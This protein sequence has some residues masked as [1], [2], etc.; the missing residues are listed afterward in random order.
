MAHLA[1]PFTFNYS[2]LLRFSRH[3]ITYVAHLAPGTRMALGERKVFVQKNDFMSG[4]RAER[5]ILRAGLTLMRRLQ[6]K[7]DLHKNEHTLNQK[8]YR[9]RQK[10]EL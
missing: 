4:R 9:V 7:V 10:R 6:H 5:A 2:F 8:G 3:L 1:D